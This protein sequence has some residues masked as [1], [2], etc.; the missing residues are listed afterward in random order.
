M[1]AEIFFPTVRLDVNLDTIPPAIRHPKLPKLLVANP[2]CLYH[3]SC[4]RIERNI[5]LVKESIPIGGKEKDI[6]RV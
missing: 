3:P 6:L 5:L 4:F 2:L 1:P